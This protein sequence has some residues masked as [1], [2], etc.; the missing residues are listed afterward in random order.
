MNKLTDRNIKEWVEQAV[1]DKIEFRRAVHVILYAISNTPE[2]K[3][4]MVIKGGL[5]LAVKYESLRFT[6]DIDFSTN[7]NLNEINAELVVENLKKGLAESVETLEYDLDCS[8]QSYKIL[9]PKVKEPTFP[10]IKI[11]I[12]YAYRGLC[13]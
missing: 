3:A 11:K 4:I 8:V 10:S 12:G 7:K 6:K 9:P 5:L 1:Q 2:L 13:I